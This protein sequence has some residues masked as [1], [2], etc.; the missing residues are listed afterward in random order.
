M[1]AILI[2]LPQDHRCTLLHAVLWNAE[3][4]NQGFVRARQAPY[5]LMYIP[6]HELFPQSS[7]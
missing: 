5:Q 7:H 6:D 3:D 4:K 1:G 2:K